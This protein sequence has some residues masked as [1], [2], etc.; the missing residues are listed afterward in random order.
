VK[1][2]AGAWSL[3]LTGMANIGNLKQISQDINSLTMRFIGVYSG[4]K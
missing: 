1:T 4:I 3:S 2:F